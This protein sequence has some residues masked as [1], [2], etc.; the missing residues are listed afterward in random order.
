VFPRRVVD[1]VLGEALLPSLRTARCVRWRGDQVCRA[2]ELACPQ[3]ALWLDPR[4]TW[5]LDESA[6]DGCGACA[7]ACPSQAIDAPGVDANAM[8][9][10][11]RGAERV[12]LACTRSDGH[13][14]VR[15]PCL[16][17]IHPE[18]LAT[19]FLLHP[20]ATVVLDL[21]NCQGCAAGALRPLIESQARQAREYARLA[22]VPA[23]VRVIGRAEAAPERAMDRRA[24]FRLA[25]ERTTTF[26]AARLAEDDAS[27]AG[28]SL[29]HRHALLDAVRARLAATHPSGA[30]T[31]PVMLPVPAAW[32]VDWD[33]SDA[34]DGCAAEPRFRCVAACPNGAW[35]V[36]RTQGDAAL[37]HDAASCSGCGACERAC[38][39]SA[40]SARPAALAADGGRQAKRTLA[41]AV[42]RS[43]RQ[44]PARG[45]DGLCRHCR[46]RL[47]LA[48][49]SR[50]GA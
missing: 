47:A 30:P 8:R 20:D 13:A 19:G 18:A 7:S 9:R 4:G 12:T 24:F 32:Y 29:P 36:V 38:P 27:V 37:T 33:V 25:R 1:A 15:V 26:V 45:P 50:P 42:C 41:A 34:C 14:D 46:T 22:G 10:A 11:W 16:A 35:R 43:C 23:D 31:G 21:S 49:R 6:C 5:H 39:R 3:Q 17:G 48:E 40:L 28:V 44:A 2:C